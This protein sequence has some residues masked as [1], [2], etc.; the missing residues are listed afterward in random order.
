MTQTNVGS[1]RGPVLALETATTL[2]SVAV[3]RDGRLLAE[4]TLGVQVRHS[5]SLLPAIRFALESARV[6]RD[7]LNAIVV[8]A[9]PGSFTGVRIASATAKG[10][11]HALGLPLFA[12]STLAALAAGTGRTDRTIC[13][14]IEARREEVFAGCYRFPRNGGMETIMPPVVVEVGELA[15]RFA[16]ARPLW[17]G[18]TARFADRLAG[19]G[20]VALG[21]TGHPR[22]SAL[23]WLAH[24]APVEGSVRDSARWTPEYVR[25]PG[26][27][28]PG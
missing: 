24:H 1:P 10:L 12:Y 3:G 20:D 19:H 6:A 2:G 21:P 7:E 13:A 22:A 5:E 17:V 23:L 26:V 18:H 8:G 27:T 4:V 25:P 14:L 15:A 11:V 9:G 28:L 16:E